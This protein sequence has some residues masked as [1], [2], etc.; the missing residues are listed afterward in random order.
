MGWSHFYLL[1]KIGCTLARL[2]SIILT[3]DVFPGDHPFLIKL[4]PLPPALQSSA[5][6][7]GT[8]TGDGIPGKSIE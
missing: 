2:N 1:A 7:A 6:L 5:V 3:S 8:H 4:R